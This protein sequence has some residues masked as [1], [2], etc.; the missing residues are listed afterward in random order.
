LAEKEKWSPDFHDF[1]A[2]CLVKN[3]Q[4]RS[5]A[6]DLL[7]HP[8]IQNAAP[9]SELQQL[10]ESFIAFKE[11]KRVEKETRVK[12]ILEFSKNGTIFALFN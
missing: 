6:S 4:Q 12:R 10:A 9:R 7:K 8:F 11:Q 3:P 5:S 2:K 1:I